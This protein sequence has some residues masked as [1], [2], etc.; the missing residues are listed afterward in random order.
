MLSLSKIYLR[1]TC[2]KRLR[3]QQLIPVFVGDELNSKHM[4]SDSNICHVLIPA[5]SVICCGLNGELIKYNHQLRVFQ[6]FARY[7][8]AKKRIVSRG[9]KGAALPLAGTPVTQASH[10]DTSPR[11]Q[12]INQPDYFCD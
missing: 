4:L 7:R 3:F 9:W 12:S 8:L 2:D 11:C 5:K 1:F 6:R 10:T